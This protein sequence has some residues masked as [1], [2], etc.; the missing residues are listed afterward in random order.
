MNV[1]KFC[2]YMYETVKEQKKV[3]Q[4]FKCVVIGHYYTT[5]KI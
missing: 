4:W 5:Y 3:K 2:R 1:A